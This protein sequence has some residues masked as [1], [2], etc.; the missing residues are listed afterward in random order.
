MKIKEQKLCV[1]DSMQYVH[2]LKMRVNLCK[3]LGC[4]NL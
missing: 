2:V 4:R 1:R 3:F